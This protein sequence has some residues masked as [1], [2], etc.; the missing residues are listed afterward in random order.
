MAKISAPWY[1][2]QANDYVKA[3]QE[4]ILNTRILELSSKALYNLRCKLFQKLYVLHALDL[5]F[6]PILSCQPFFQGSLDCDKSLSILI[7]HLACISARHSAV[8]GTSVGAHSLIAFFL[9]GVRYF[10]LP[11]S[12]IN[13]AWYIPNSIQA[14]IGC[15]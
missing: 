11:C 3:V 7:V 6:C 14:H 8:D 9:K 12:S 2:D 1:G 5:V 4:I 15:S 10:H 13:Q